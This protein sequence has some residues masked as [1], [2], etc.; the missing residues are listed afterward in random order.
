MI[1]GALI[2][3]LY[4]GVAAEPTESNTGESS[5]DVNEESSSDSIIGNVSV[6]GGSSSEEGESSDL[7]SGLESDTESDTD[8]SDVSTSS[9]YGQNAYDPTLGNG[10]VE[11]GSTPSND[12]DTTSSKAEVS[13]KVETNKHTDENNIQALIMIISGVVLAAGSIFAL[14]YV[15]RKAFVFENKA[16][17]KEGKDMRKKKN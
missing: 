8:S 13:S 9:R 1:I 16:K 7:E 10:G 3:V 17:N 2:C 5:S 15:N 6:E 11:F 4:M 12:I 14:V